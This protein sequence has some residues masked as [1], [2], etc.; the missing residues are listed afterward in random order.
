M[1]DSTTV[2][3]IGPFHRIESDTQTKATA[4]KQEK[5]GEVWGRTPRGGMEPTVQAYTGSLDKSDRGIEFTTDTAP[6]RSSSPFQARWYM[7]RTPGVQRRY[8]E[9]EEFAC[10][11]ADIKN[12]QP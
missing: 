2:A 1:D 7:T 5:T 8:E 6:H 3:S 11:L 12:M 9:G 4:L 10:I